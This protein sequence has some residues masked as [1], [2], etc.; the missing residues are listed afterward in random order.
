MRKSDHGFYAGTVFGFPIYIETSALYLAPWLLLL[1]LHQASGTGL[2]HAIA[3]VAVIIVSVLLHEL[4]HAVSAQALG[5]PVR[6]IALTWFGGYAAFWVA[7]TH[8][9]DAIIAFAGPAL[10]LA[11]AAFLFSVATTFP[12]AGGILQPSASAD[13]IINIREPGLLEDVVRTGAYVNLALGILNL[14]PG[15]P[16]DGGHILRAVLASQMS[17]G[18]ANWLAAWAGVLIGAGA[19]AYAIWVESFSFL[20]LGAFVGFSAWSHLRAMRYD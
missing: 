19:L 5:V 7:P 9:R 17:E 12:A 8:W 6:H 20:F 11:T 16:L 15:L 1:A 18:R 2:V 13:L 14:L 4:G 10:N 3:Y